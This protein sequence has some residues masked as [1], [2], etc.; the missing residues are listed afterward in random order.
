MNET[1]EDY[2]K[3]IYL[4]SRDNHGGWVSNSDIANYMKIK[5]SSVTNMLHKLKDLGYIDWSPRKSLRLTK[6]GKSIAKQMVNR[7]YTLKDFFVNVLNMKNDDSINEICCK[8]EHH[9]NKKA[10]DALND[11]VLSTQ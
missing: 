2:L 5:P 10:F 1:Y 9:L 8:I 3:S 7:Y 6:Q 4:I 11:L